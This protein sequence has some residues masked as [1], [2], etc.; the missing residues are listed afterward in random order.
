MFHSLRSHV[1]RQH[2]VHVCVRQEADVWVLHE[3]RYR[4]AYR[5]ASLSFSVGT[6]AISV[7]R[8]AKLS[9]LRRS[10]LLRRNN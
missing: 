9:Y 5:I 7:C 6:L 3:E 10:V 4:L 2:E 8:I 1:A